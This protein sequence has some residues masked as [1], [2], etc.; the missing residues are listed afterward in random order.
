[1]DM[2]NTLLAVMPLAR[3]RAAE[4]APWI[5]STIAEFGITDVAM[6]LAQVA[7]ESG[8]LRFVEEIASGAAYE[9]RKD[10]G[11]TQPGDGKKFKGHGLIQITGR[12]NHSAVSRYFFGD[13]RLLD[14]PSW[15]T[16]PEGAARSAGWYWKHS[17]KGD[18]DGLTLEACTRKI[19]GGL[20]GLDDRGVYL[21][22]ARRALR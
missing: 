17:G 4:F 16:T 6:F 10:L 15:L 18:L 12:A 21:T 8:Q 3:R 19:N 1:M 13:D 14:D 9:G 20:N 5:E 11:N 2:T 22:R 7:H